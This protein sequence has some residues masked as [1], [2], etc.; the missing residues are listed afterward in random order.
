MC[1]CPNTKYTL[2]HNVQGDDRKSFCQPR[3]NYL[4]TNSICL[5]TQ[6]YVSNV[7]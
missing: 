4:G 3:F 7:Q 5:F 2:F 1:K 6:E